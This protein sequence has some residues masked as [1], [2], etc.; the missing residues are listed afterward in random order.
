MKISILIAVEPNT[1][2][3]ADA[4]ASI[5]AQ[6]HSNWEVILLD[7]S[8]DGQVA[9]LIPLLGGNADVR[10]ERLATPIGLPAMRNRLLDLARGE[11]AAFL[12][13]TAA[14]FPRHLAVAVEHLRDDADVVVANI[15]WRDPDG[16]TVREFDVPAQ[17]ITSPLRTLFAREVVPAISCVT[18]RRTTALTAGRFDARFRSGEARDYWLRCAIAGA[19]F[20]PTHQATCRCPRPDLSAGPRAIE[21][22]DELVQFYEKHFD[23]SSLPSALRR[24]LLSNSLVAQGRLLRTI[25]PTRAARCF[26]RAWSLQPV[27]VQTLGQLALTGWRSTGPSDPRDDL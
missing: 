1:G 20:R 5:A 19:R 26:W 17:L 14:W 27:Y 6:S 4:L 23:L 15:Q 2:G 12:E 11:A 3:L 10:H 18:L 22:T 13:T 21:K 9:S 16:S 24:R 8:T 25:D 7:A